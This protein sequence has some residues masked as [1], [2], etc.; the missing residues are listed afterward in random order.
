MTSIV[1]VRGALPEHRYA[2]P[3]LTAEFASLV[4]TS[5]RYARALLDRF[6]ANAGVSSRHLGLPIVLQPGR[7]S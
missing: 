5:S 2:Q 1:S 3:D 6:H 4:T 7:D